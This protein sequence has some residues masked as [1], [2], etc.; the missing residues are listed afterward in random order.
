MNY[1]VILPV[2]VNMILNSLLGLVSGLAP[3]KI[4]M[5]VV[6][7]TLVSLTIFLMANKGLTVKQTAAQVAER[8]R[9]YLNRAKWF[10]LALISY[11]A[12][13]LYLGLDNSSVFFYVHVLIMFNMV[14]YLL[15]LSSCELGKK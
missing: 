7:S 13:R 8:F 15:S 2:I 1:Q 6:Y 5:V 4:I 9:V 10:Q 12:I 11:L 3:V 14:G